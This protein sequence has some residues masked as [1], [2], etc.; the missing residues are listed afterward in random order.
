MMH[1]LMILSSSCAFNVTPSPVLMGLYSS[2]WAIVS[3]GSK[4]HKQSHFNFRSWDQ[5]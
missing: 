3:G 1:T 4:T 2:C 5:Q